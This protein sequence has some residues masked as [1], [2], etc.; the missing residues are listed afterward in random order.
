LD[1]QGDVI[2]MSSTTSHNWARSLRT[3]F[4][5]AGYAN[6]RVKPKRHDEVHRM[7]YID[8]ARM[9]REMGHL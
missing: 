8:D 4:S 1:H 6:H 2:E 9:A 7:R 5:R 3:V